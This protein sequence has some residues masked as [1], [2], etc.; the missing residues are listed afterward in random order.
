MH[1]P[2]V[3]PPTRQVHVEHVMGT[4]V[5]F[6][7]RG[8][9]PAGAAIARAVASLHEADATW[10]TYRA[11]SA[12]RRL[13]AGELTL[14]QVPE[15]VRRVLAT[16]EELRRCT[17]GLFDVRALGPLDPSAYVKGWAAQRAAELLVA[18]GFADV[19]V[20]AGGD[21]VCRG[22]PAPGARWRV[23]VQH[24]LDAGAVAAVVEAGD[25]AVATSGL[26]ERGGHIRD[27]RT[28]AVPEGLLSVTVTGPDLG[29][30][31][32]LSTAAFALGADAA[33]WTLELPA[34]YEA[35]TITADERMFAT[36]GFE[37]VEATR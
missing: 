23:G 36:P 16:C 19:S 11:D 13:D 25:L 1:A 26:Y 24:P 2:T 35:L 22:R 7:V 15:E 27:P 4:V 37:G 8:P 3:T 34:G 30:A 17:R 32:A 12:V 10:S 9:E 21:V 14:D 31:D 5:S 20:A 33:A 28:R 29:R 6:D 18:D